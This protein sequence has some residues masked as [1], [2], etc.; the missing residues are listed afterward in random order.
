MS[1]AESTEEE[2]ESTD[3]DYDFFGPPEIRPPL[4]SCPKYRKYNVD[5]FEF[6]KVLGKGSYG[7][8][9]VSDIVIVKSVLVV[10]V[11]V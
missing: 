5:D 6:I 3:T 7:K 9:S 10:L 1:E 8:T 11:I 2:T 4:Q